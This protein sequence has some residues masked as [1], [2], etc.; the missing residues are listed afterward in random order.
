MNMLIFVL[1]AQIQHIHKVTQQ[2]I[3]H[4]VRS[5]KMVLSALEGISLYQ[6]KDTINLTVKV[7]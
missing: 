1:L 4:F 7:M 3:A 5:A 6:L 2:A